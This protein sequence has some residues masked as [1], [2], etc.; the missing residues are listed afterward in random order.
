MSEINNITENL[1][2]KFIEGKTNEAETQKVLDYINASQENMKEYLTV[3]ESLKYVEDDADCAGVKID[4][5]EQK[6]YV[7]NILQQNKKKQKTP[8]IR[9]N[10]KKIWL[11][12]SSAAA[13]AAV[14]ILFILLSPGETPGENGKRAQ[15]DEK[16]FA[17]SETYSDFIKMIT[18][19]KSIAFI[20]LQ[21]HGSFNF[22][23]ETTADTVMFILNDADGESLI[24][25]KMTDNSFCVDFVDYQDN[26]KFLWCIKAIYNSGKEGMQSGTIN[27]VK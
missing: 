18:P 9:L 13:I 17:S 22:S 23:W 16:K 14:I 5:E 10:I 4:L 2:C 19:D 15:T 6:K 8:I 3:L 24:R 20:T 21:D 25:K 7:E 26:D 11:V 12:A 27:I 1:L